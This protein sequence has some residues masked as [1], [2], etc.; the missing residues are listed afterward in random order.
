VSKEKNSYNVALVMRQLL[1]DVSTSLYLALVKEMQGRVYSCAVIHAKPEA[2]S[3]E[4][5]KF[6]ICC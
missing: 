5:S 4:I 2:R 1:A 6:E 3:M